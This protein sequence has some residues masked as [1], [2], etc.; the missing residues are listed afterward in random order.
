MG[1]LIVSNIPK[2]Y[3]YSPPPGAGASG[4]QGPVFQLTVS[5]IERLAKA[6]VSIQ[7]DNARLIP[8]SDPVPEPTLTE[9][10]WQ[11]W[12]RAN[13]TDYAAKMID[14]VASEHGD[15]AYLFVQPRD[16]PPFILEDERTL[17]PSDA[18]MGKLWMWRKTQDAAK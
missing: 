14:V 12:H 18:L 2:S 4:W 5:E 10:F 16:A 6:G 13:P 9:A 11:R 17:F 8:I 7:F 15:K 3:P 1:R